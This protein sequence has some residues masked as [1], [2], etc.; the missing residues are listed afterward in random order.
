[1]KVSD[2]LTLVR[3]RIR[4]N[5][6]VEYDDAELIGYINDAIS[7]WSAC[8]V[9]NSDL[10]KVKTVS[11]NPYTDVPDDFA[12]FCGVYPITIESGRIISDD[13]TQVLCKYYAYDGLISDVEDNL[14][15]SAPEISILLQLT[16]I[17]ALNRNQ[18]DVT[19]DASLSKALSD[20][21]STSKV[22]NS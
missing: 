6:R 3:A 16:C 20:V 17:Y 18:F 21:V 19:T 8:S 14:I 2:F 9:A 15:Y 7:Y 11:V 12:K 5:Y 1:M 22:R 13:G 4:D 10:L